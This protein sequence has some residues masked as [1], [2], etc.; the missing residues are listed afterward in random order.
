MTKPAI[1]RLIDPML[2]AIGVDP[3]Q[4][5]ILLDLFSKL[6]NRQEF[7]AGNARLSLRITVG[8][9]AVLS[10]LANLLIALIGSPPVRLYVFGNF[11]FT[12][13]LLTL[14]LTMEAVNAF[15]NPVEASVLA[16]Q[17]IHDRSYFA[18]KFTY[19]ASVV[20]YVVLPINIVP[21]LAGATLKDSSWVYPLSYLIAVYLMGLFL[22]LVGC[23]ILGLLFRVF[24]AARI[25]NTIL[26][27]QIGFFTFIGT[28]PRVLESLFRKARIS[29]DMTR[30]A[31]LP[32]NWFV[33]LAVPG[34]NFMALFL[35]L[36]A[37]LSMISCAALIIVGIR[38]LSAGYLMRV[39]T[40]L[41]SGPSRERKRR[42]LFGPAV[43]LITQ[44]PSGRAAFDFVYAMAKTD[45]Q[46]RRS[47]YPALIQ[48]L[49]LPLIGVIRGGL[50]H[51]PFSPG[52]PTVAHFLPH[53]G[54]II[55]LTAC[56][57]I[58]YSNQY[59]AAWVF[60]TLPLEGIHSFVRGIFWATWLPLGALSLV[61]MPILAWSWG[62]RDATLFTAYTMAVGS[63]Y[64]SIEMFLVDGLPF[65]NPPESLKGSM[66]GPLVIVSGIGALIIVGLQW[67]F[68]FQSRFVAAGAVLAFAGAAYVIAG[69]S[70]RYVETNVMHN[71]HVIATGRTAMFK[72]VG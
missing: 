21:A 13:F 25:R 43:R 22:A 6:T 33:G 32:L 12:T 8:M 4:Y 40:L 44:K 48:I 17:P 66:S 37:L 42:G 30:S 18:A 39:H 38:C 5:S 27:I 31:A 58:K 46:F 68:I 71:L 20:A 54:G 57:A 23:G 16:H 35:S 1:H 10:A 53:I 34:R 70:L 24:P 59:K 45:W 15:F 28:G 61:L 9:F 63:F 65:A 51:S 14:I 3:R 69:A 49:I 26:W 72:E 55:G 29:F 50:G 2:R 52:A 11:V 60:L 47:V 7:E 41:R 36:S 67:L 19:L 62:I 56:V 64:L